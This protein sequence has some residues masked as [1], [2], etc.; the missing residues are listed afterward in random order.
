MAPVVADLRLKHESMRA[1]AFTFFRATFYLWAQFWEHLPAPI[2]KAPRILGIGDAHVENFGTWR[3]A[4]GRLVW[5][6][7]DFD[8][9]AVVPY[10]NDLVRI[11]VSGVLA[12]ERGDLRITAQDIV[13]ALLLGY[14]A[15]LSHH[16]APFVIE[17]R[18]HW[19]RKLA[20]GSARAP[21]RYWSKFA[22]LERWRGPLPQRAA[23]LVRDVPSDAKLIRIVHRIAG[24]G[25]LGRPRVAALYEWQ[26]GYIAREVK[27]RAPSAWTWAN[28]TSVKQN[29]AALPRVWQRAV[30]CQDPYSRVTRRWIGKRLGPD[31]SRIDLASLP[32]MRQEGALLRAM[33][34]E[35]ANIHLGSGSA[36]KKVQ[37][38]L[39]TLDRNWLADAT[40]IML[41]ATRAAFQEWRQR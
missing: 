16:G 9:S 21:E 26:G 38:H 40:A 23:E 5:G 1:D 24:A 33:G 19:L 11:A 10:T 3:D 4:Q 35:T 34:W 18:N 37:Q 27:A 13:D 2:S 20:L 8:E 31:C 6:V 25:S 29:T 41:H 30:R 32:K 17:E 22:A 15:A 7:N 14:S 28:D 12:K 36:P 39:R